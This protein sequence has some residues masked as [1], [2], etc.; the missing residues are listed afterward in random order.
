[1][2]QW[3]LAD[4]DS[5]QVQLGERSRTFDR[6]P[7]TGG[8]VCE[9]ESKFIQP[10]LRDGI[11]I[12]DQQA[13]VVNTVWVMGQQRIGIIFGDVF[14]AESGISRLLGCNCPINTYIGAVRAS[15]R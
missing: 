9:P 13:A 15:R 10:L 12:G 11:R 5:A 3:M 2:R 14:P 1:M 4:I 8:R 7:N 6:K